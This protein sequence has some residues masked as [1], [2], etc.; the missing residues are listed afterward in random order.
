[1][2]G[3]GSLNAHLMQYTANATGIPVI[4]GPAECTALGN[5]LLQLKAA[6]I[7]DGT[8]R[9]REIARASV[10][11]REY[12]PQDMEEW[13]RAYSVFLEIQDACRSGS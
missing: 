2:I 12:L 11:V 6:G 7:A 3:G 1:M 13:D 9:I 4:A 5:V 8:D 10:N